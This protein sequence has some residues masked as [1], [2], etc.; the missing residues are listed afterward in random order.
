[1]SGLAKKGHFPKVG[2]LN[3]QGLA[4]EAVAPAIISASR[5]TDIP[6]FYARWLLNRLKL[7]HC[8]WQS[9]FNNK[10]TYVSFQNC[11]AIV[12]WSKNPAPIMPH[13]RFLDGM[14]IAYY[15]QFTLND[16]EREGLEP[17]LPPLR[18]RIETFRALA[19]RLGRERVIWRF[20]PL[21]LTPGSRPRDLLLKI[22]R[23]GRELRGYTDRLVFSF[24]DVGRYRK[25]RHNLTRQC[26]CFSGA[27]V[28]AA[29]PNPAQM[30]E[31][32]EGLA[33]IRDAWRRSG[34]GM[35]IFAC[36]EAVSLAEFDIRP[37]SC[38]DQGLLAR[39]WAGM[40]ATPAAG[41]TQLNLLPAAV[42]GKDRGQRKGCGCATAKDIGAYDTCA[43]FCAYCYAN[44]G[45]GAVLAKMAKFEPRAEC[46]CGE[47]ARGPAP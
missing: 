3:D 13:L 25:V 35:D 9:P 1:M 18:K 47:S 22:W 43:H 16:Y 41:G 6:A 2:I 8:A 15:F 11:R 20:D 4:V 14:G 44:S 33:K 45:R 17:G 24:V 29:E 7:G 30:L 26:A 42:P 36:C 10:N 12:F 28:M 40:T 27:N 19:G 46:L 5:A 32:G 31:L 37:A 34:W 23:L 21:V 38:I 39:L